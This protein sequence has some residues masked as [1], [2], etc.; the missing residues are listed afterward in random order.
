VVFTNGR[1]RWLIAMT[2]L[3]EKLYAAVRGSPRLWQDFEAL[4]GMGGRFAGTD[5]ER[6]AVAFLKE[7][8]VEDFGRAP[9]VFALDYDNWTRKG[10][11]LEILTPERKSLPCHALVWSPKTP[12]GG[13]EADVVDLGR[14]TPED[15]HTNTDAVRGRIVLV[16]HE[17]MFA[18]DTV[19]RRAKYD[20]ARAAGA[21]GFL[22]ANRLPGD[23]L[24]TGSSG[25]N[26]SDDIPAAGITFEGA[27]LLKSKNGAFP[28]VC[29]AIDVGTGRSS[30]E[31]LI[32]ELPGRT[33]ELVVL[34]AHI[35]G[36]PLGESALDNG[37]GLA[38]ALAVARAVAPHVGDMQ[39]GVRLCLFNLEEWALAGSARYVDQL[40][41]SDRDRIALNVNLDSV[42]GHDRLTAL[43]SG[44]PKVESFLRQVANAAGA[45]LDY[46][47]PL[48]RNSD[49]YN[50]ARH[51][52]PAFRLVAG[53][54][55]PDSALR[56][57]LT[58]GDTRD[59][60]DPQ[61]LETA[62]LLTGSI[63]LAACTAPALH[64]RD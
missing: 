63:L 38:V 46:Y 3:T 57:V 61:A 55:A 59:K 53:F 64:L 47:R 4:C 48:M 42:A 58:P 8:M 15:I 21:V 13:L 19:H 18:A 17:Y 56:H 16:R 28:R 25:R 11:S 20:A 44:F 12:P 29:L 23:A 22:I 24:V 9:E 1:H 35:D 27:A 50:F 60:A 32:L 34:S 52:I 37:T 62:A 10:Q 40:P 6:Q 26:R 5:S 2:G 14:G 54:N 36:H 51:G 41:Q 49:H 39:R 45:E 7:R 33:D 43:T 31:S 30:A